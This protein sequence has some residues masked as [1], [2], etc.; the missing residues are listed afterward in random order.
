[1]IVYWL[2]LVIGYWLHFI[3]LLNIVSN[4]AIEKPILSTS[5]IIS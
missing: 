4:T 1:M 5:M 3:E 2:S